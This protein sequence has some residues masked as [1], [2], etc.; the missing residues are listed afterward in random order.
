MAFDVCGW[1]RLLVFL[2]LVGLIVHLESVTAGRCLIDRPGNN[3]SMSNNNY[4]WLC[5]NLYMNSQFIIDTTDV[6]YPVTE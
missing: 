5:C 3:V 4:C 2:V 1:Y 6:R